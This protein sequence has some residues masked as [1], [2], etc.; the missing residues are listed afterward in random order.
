MDTIDTI[1]HILSNLDTLEILKCSSINKLFYKATN[2][3]NIWMEKIYH[4]FCPNENFLIPIPEQNY[5]EYKQI[6]K[7]Y[8][9]ITSQNYHILEH[10][11][12][13]KT[14][15]HPPNIRRT[16]KLHDVNLLSK[17]LYCRVDNED[18]DGIGN[19][20]ILLFT[21]HLIEN[22]ILDLITAVLLNIEGQSITCSNMY[23][24]IMEKL[25]MVK[26]SKK[27]CE[28]NNSWCYEI[29]IQLNTLEK[30]IPSIHHKL[31]EI[32]MTFVDEHLFQNAHIIIEHI[33]LDEKINPT[34]VLIFH[35][36]EYWHN[37]LH[38]KDPV[39]INMEILFPLVGMLIYLI[40]LEMNCIVSFEFDSMLI[41]INYKVI[42]IQQREIFKL[43]S[44]MYYV[45]LERI[46]QQKVKNINDCCWS[47]CKTKV[48][49]QINNENWKYEAFSLCV[50]PLCYNRILYSREKVE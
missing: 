9:Q 2:N 35:S 23:L 34:N 10:N 20:K 45:P 39:R 8:Y 3:Q 16:I 33:S 50:I 1:I 26:L 7:K 12:T 19:I 6:Y 28:K 5:H 46:V 40:N 13:Q 24:M 37:Y 21:E 31:M 42:E 11:C 41:T 36:I 32:K 38:C 18:Y 25:S 29:N 14:L 30:W 22:S 48:V 49:L 44:N 15:P 43:E 47:H 27:Y 4:D 17:Y